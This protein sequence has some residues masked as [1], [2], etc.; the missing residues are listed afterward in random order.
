MSKN[1]ST[2]R[3]YAPDHERRRKDRHI[4]VV[5]VFRLLRENHRLGET[6]GDVLT[7]LHA[8]PNVVNHPSVGVHE[9]S[10]KPRSTTPHRP[11]ELLQ[12]RHKVN[13]VRHRAC[14][15][16]VGMSHV[17]VSSS[18][19]LPTRV[20]GRKSVYVRNTYMNSRDIFKAWPTNGWS[21]ESARVEKTMVSMLLSEQRPAWGCG[22]I[23]RVPAFPI[24]Y[25]L[26]TST[27]A[28]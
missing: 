28:S 2:H 10:M 3:F 13:E 9:V 11:R 1:F 24:L 22:L 19:A 15:I 14:A 26:F 7:A 21:M 4:D 6:V 23:G 27:R 25:R 8:H 20:E 12:E 16:P 18:C 17:F 5:E